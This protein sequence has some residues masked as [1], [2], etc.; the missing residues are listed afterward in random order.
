MTETGVAYLPGEGTEDSVVYSGYI[1]KSV[2]SLAEGYQPG[3][4]AKLHIEG[5]A[6]RIGSG[7]SAWLSWATTYKV[8][9]EDGTPLVSDT[10]HHSIAPWTTHDYADNK[11][12]I[13]LGPMPDSPIK[14]YVELWAGGSPDV[15]LDSRNF[16]VPLYGV[17]PPSEIPWKWVAVIGGALAVIIT[18]IV[19]THP[20]TKVRGFRRR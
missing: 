3:E 19:L 18:V 11:F 20:S 1:V 2:P 7:A 12:D 8:F 9:Q 13:S 4:E 17:A 16:V 5:H 15:L 10:R 6:E 14:G